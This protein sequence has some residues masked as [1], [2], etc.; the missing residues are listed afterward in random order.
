MLELREKE[1]FFML[2]KLKDIDFVLIGGYA[3][4]TYTQPRFSIDCDIVVQNNEDAKKIKD[5]LIR[6]G[7]KEKE[8][9]LNVPYRG[10]F[11][12]LIKQID[13]YS[14]SFDLLIGTVIDRQTNL[15]FPAEMI[16]ENS[17]IRTLVGKTN[18][19]KMKLR[20]ADPEL[21]IVMKLAP[22]RTSDVRDIFMLLEG[23]IDVGYVLS[24]IKK[25]G[26][27]KNL[28]RFKDYITG[29]D[30]KDNLQGVFGK[31]DEKTFNKIVEKTK[32]L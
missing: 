24:E 26:L 28:Q 25:Y 4:N 14:V 17:K 30:F 9:N 5:V 15:K 11:S 13:H 32:N 1:I 29:A 7:Y 23:N 6:E 20:I 3:V 27:Q 8:I 31:V 12:C 10:K 21:L 2:E 19:V 22:S 16:F 18:P